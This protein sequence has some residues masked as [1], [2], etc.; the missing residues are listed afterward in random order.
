MGNES[1]STNHRR[2][3][4]VMDSVETSSHAS[5]NYIQIK[6]GGSNTMHASPGHLDLSKIF[7][8][9]KLTSARKLSKEQSNRI[10][11]RLMNYDKRKK[12]AILKVKEMQEQKEAEELSRIQK[13]HKSKKTSHELEGTF[14]RLVSDAD[15]RN[16]K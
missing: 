8:F 12:M 3:E 5:R 16:K 7:D 6:S 14:K 13:M 9:S 1:I 2:L 10:S 11:E 15:H 4:R